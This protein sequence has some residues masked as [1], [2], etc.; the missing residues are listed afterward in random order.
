MEGVAIKKIRN[1][2][3]DEC[4]GFLI[5]SMVVLHIFSRVDAELDWFYR[6]LFFF[7][8]WFYYKSGAFFNANGIH[9]KTKGQILRKM[10]KSYIVYTCVGIVMILPF[11]NLYELLKNT[12]SSL[13]LAGSC[14]A[15]IP[16]WFLFSLA[17][18]QIMG[19]E[20]I[21]KFA[22]LDKK[23]RVILLAITCGA[24]CHLGSR[25]TWIG[26]S[27][28]GTFFYILGYYIK[29]TV[30]KLILLSSTIILIF[31]IFICPSFVHLRSMR[32]E[33]GTYEAWLISSLCAIIL[34]NFVFRYKKINL[35]VLELIDRNAMTILCTHWIILN[36]T[37]E[38]LELTEIVSRSLQMLIYALSVLIFE[39]L[40]C[41]LANRFHLV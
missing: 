18:S 38:Y 30:N 41:R 36:I 33:M 8:P 35:K 4:S 29:F 13:L 28:V 15:N 10:L 5:L 23:W 40:Y 24:I 31:I 11:F 14:Y 6:T 21:Y 39:F 20:F 37:Q 25:F 1:T 17:V 9:H 12:I 32:L 2:Y 34:I 22:K 26:Y 7:L 19:L 3:I 16:M 27:V